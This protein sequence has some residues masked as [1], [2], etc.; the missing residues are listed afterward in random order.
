MAPPTET[1][2][3]EVTPS[4]DAALNLLAYAPQ[5][6]SGNADR[7]IAKY[8]DGLMYVPGPGWFAWMG[9]RW[10]ADDDGRLIRRAKETARETYQLGAA[11]EK[12]AGTDEARGRAGALMA[13]A[14]RMESA[15]AIRAMVSLAAADR[16]VIASVDDLD[17]D[18]YL[19]NVANGTIDLRT[20]DLLAPEKGHRLTKWTQ[21]VYDPK[22]Q[23][24]EWS[25]LLAHI[26]RGYDGTLVEYLRLACGYSI[27]GSVEEDVAHLVDGPGGTGKSTFI[28]AIR[29]SVGEYASTAPFDMFVQRKGDQAHPTDLARLVGIRLVT[30]EE[31]PKNR[32]LDAAKL[33]LLAG[34]T[35]IPARFMR[36]DFFEYDPI[37]KI[38]LVSNFRPRVHAEDTAAWRRLRAVPFANAIPLDD[39][40]T[41]VRKHLKTNPGAQSAVLA[42]LVSGARDWAAGGRLVAPE[43]V[44]ART[45][46]WRRDTDR[47]GGWLEDE[48]VLDPEGWESSERLQNS[49]NE[50]WKTYVQEKGWDPPSLMAGLGEELRAR[51]CRSEQRGTNR[52][53]GWAGIRLKNRLLA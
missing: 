3:D 46:E 21:V 53:R 9:K 13:H 49:I 18:P 31:G 45:D 15:A 44:L 6:D 30:S 40:D 5:T 7:L 34:G 50:W 20:G 17:A 16:S 19:L 8:G 25:R 47:V 42:W 2:L 48:C 27:T 36:G 43:C 33:K 26:D 4:T 23:D 10:I 11:M 35:R 1:H 12:A 24:A 22:A 28:E 37:L 14:R 32:A 39:Q 52:T 29:A 41:S 51:G 38:W